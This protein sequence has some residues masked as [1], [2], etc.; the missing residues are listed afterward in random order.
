MIA[1]IYALSSGKAVGIFLNPPGTALMW[2]VIRSERD[3]F[4]AN[5]NTMGLIYEGNE[6]GCVDIGGLSNGRTY[7][8]KPF[9]YDGVKWTGFPSKSIVPGFT[10]IDRSVD[11]LSLLRDRIDTG[12]NDLI[13]TGQLTHPNNIAP[14][15][16]ESPQIQDIN[17]PCV[18]LHISSDS[19]ESRFLGDM[20]EP[21]IDAGIGFVDEIT[22]YYS[23]YTL[24]IV[25]WA[26]NGDER[27]AY[28]KAL[29]AL[30][31]G[32]TLIFSEFGLEEMHFSFSD[33]EEFDL[34]QFPTYMSV[35]TF[36]CLAPSA[37]SGAYATVTE[38]EV[39][40]IV[41]STHDTFNII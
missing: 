23:R 39:E 24:E 27:L 22:G 19:D 25:V 11:V 7:Y 29:K 8:Y 1:V 2:R 28:R 40:A 13:K 21:D 15:V 31:I 3:E 9:Y 38:I 14:V 5:E 6:R 37:I 34:Y 4:L 17:L 36:S 41:A 18:T 30:F 26:K 33:S 20:F 35:C 16:T 12:L 32:N 10:M